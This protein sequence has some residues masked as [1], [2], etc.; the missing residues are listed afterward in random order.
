MQGTRDLTI[1]GPDL[2]KAM[3]ETRKLAAAV[4]PGSGPWDVIVV[5][6]GAAGGM[7]AYQLAT[8]GIKVL[9]LEAGRMID[10]QKEYRT[11]EWPYASLR[12]GRVPV[13]ERPID[14][15]EYN[16]YD[17]PYGNHPE[18]A[19]YKKVMSYAGNTFTRNWVVNEKEHPTT[20]TPFAWVRA[21]ILGGKTNF[22]GRGA[23]RYGPLE[24]KAASRDGYDVD[25]PIAYEDVKPYY[26]KVDQLLGC[27]GTKEGLMQVPDG[28]FQRPSKLNCVEVHFK[29]AIAKMGRHYIPGRAGVTTDGVLNKYRARCMGRGRCGRGCDLNASFHSPTGLIYPARDTGQLTI[30]PQSIVSE[31]LFDEVTNKA[32]GVRVIDAV[33]RDVMDFKAR[34]VILGAGTLEST[35]IL[36]NSRSRRHPNGLGNSSGVLGCYLSEHMMG[37]RGSG[38]IPIRKGTQPTLDDGRPVAPYVPRFRNLTERHPRFIRGYHFQGGGGCAEYPGMAHEIEGFGSAFKR[39]VREWYPTPISLGGFGEVLPRKENRVLLD[40]AVKDAWGIPV[41]RFDYRFRDNELKMAEDMAEQ[42]EEM[43]TVAGAENI[44]IHR[45]PL[46]PGW[47][48]HEIGTARMG[49]DPKTSVTNKFCRLHEVSNVYLADAAPFVSG[50]TQNTTWSILAMCWRTMDYLKEEMKR[51]NV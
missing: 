9:L 4:H 42:I 20:G 33:S 19:P 31:V 8:A 23:L 27:A 37:I 13:G 12:R 40:P 11:M 46:P 5:G 36:L 22:W 48:I 16:M 34:V 44:Q 26:D 10:V 45:E 25:W 28:V 29:R 39:Q 41:L 50:G 1:E 47:S 21:R 38:Y 7:A 30:R 3:E 15:A 49:E 18:L 24:F 43:L 2:T 32:A 17:R 6:S 35:R 51:G 14:V